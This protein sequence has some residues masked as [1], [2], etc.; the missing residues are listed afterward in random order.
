MSKYKTFQAITGCQF[1]PSRKEKRANAQVLVKV[2]EEVCRNYDSTF[3][4]VDGSLYGPYYLTDITL[5]DYSN[6]PKTG[7]ILFRHSLTK[8]IY[9]EKMYKEVESI[10]LPSHVKIEVHSNILD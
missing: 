8:E 9:L 1:E 10:K 5:V 7:D 2:L 4:G 6:K 3:Y